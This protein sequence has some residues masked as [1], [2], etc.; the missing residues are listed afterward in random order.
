MRRAPQDDSELKVVKGTLKDL[1]PRAIIQWVGDGSDTI[2]VVTQSFDPKGNIV[3]SHQHRTTD[4]GV[5][6]VDET[7][8]FGSSAVIESFYSSPHTHGHVIFADVTSSDLYITEDEG[9][10]FTRVHLPFAPNTI[11]FNPNTVGLVLAHDA[12]TNKLYVSADDGHTWSQPLGDGQTHHSV[13]TFSWSEAGAGQD[14]N[15]TLYLEVLS[16]D[17]G[18]SSE[19]VRI[20]DAAAAASDAK[21]AAGENITPDGLSPLLGSVQVYPR[22]MTF[23]TRKGIFL[24]LYV[25]YQRGAFKRAEFSGPDVET[26]YIVLDTSEEQMFVVV[27]HGIAGKANIYVSERFGLKFSL[28]L[29]NVA[30]SNGALFRVSILFVARLLFCIAGCARERREEQGKEKD[31]EKKERSRLE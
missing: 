20:A 17:G 6:F 5:T 14:V 1:F 31:K 9:E 23:R 27:K 24:Q 12:T 11:V 3:Q 18:D 25:S 4:Y 2:F 7:S 15:N 8:K 13:N 10:T 22:Y 28:S 21:A 19:I 26:D 16:K 29:E 30:Y